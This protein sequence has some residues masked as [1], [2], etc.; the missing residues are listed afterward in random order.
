MTNS[1]SARMSSRRAPNVLDSFNFAFEG[2][3]HALRTQRN[4][5][6]HFAAGVIVFVLALV[7]ALLP[8]ADG[9]LT[10]PIVR[11]RMP[12]VPNSR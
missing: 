9:A 2:I 12:P 6:V 5:Q 3:V 8:S 1:R 10:A 4:M 11:P 7:S